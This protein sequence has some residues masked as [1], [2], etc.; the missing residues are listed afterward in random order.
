MCVVLTWPF[1]EPAASMYAI[2]KNHH[3]ILVQAYLSLVT[4]SAEIYGTGTAF[5]I[6]IISA[7]TRLSADMGL[8][9]TYYFTF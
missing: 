8:I 5:R 3:A 9:K 1:L 6:L 7:L 2:V 4:R